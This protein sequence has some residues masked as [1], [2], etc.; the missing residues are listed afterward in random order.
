LNE[1][2]SGDITRRVAPPTPD[3]ALLNPGYSLRGAV[4]SKEPTVS[5][6]K[7]E[8]QTERLYAKVGKIAVLGE[9]LNFAMFECSHKV[10]EVRGLPQ[11][12][13]QTVLVGQNL[14][15]M[16]RT[17]ESL[18]K[19]H[20]AGDTETIGMIDH[21]SNRLDNIIGRR[22]DTV[23][24]LWFI[25]WGN[26]ETESYEVAGSIK[27][28]RDIG[29]KGQGGVKYT[30]KDTKDF[31]EIIEEMQKLTSLVARFRGCVVMPVF[32]PNAGKPTNNFHYDAK[33][34]LIDAHLP[35]PTK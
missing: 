30:D 3:F 15:K 28:T 5:K 13:A 4:M 31:E 16:R 27:G 19:V 10:L 9:H 17:W 1:V 7:R 25:G 23:H 20:Y 26:E 22:N 21:L 32:N 2:K 12:Y 6:E 14:E 34:Q 18:M 33:G 11:N 8:A 24:R 29:K 35:G